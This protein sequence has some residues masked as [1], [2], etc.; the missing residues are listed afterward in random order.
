MITSPSTRTDSNTP[1]E[2]RNM[3]AIVQD[4]YGSAD[5]LDARQIERPIPG[6]GE[7]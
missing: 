3:Q 2:K 1:E 6:D 7:C 4:R 5:V